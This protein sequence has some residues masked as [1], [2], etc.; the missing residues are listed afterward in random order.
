MSCVMEEDVQHVS[1]GERGWGR[2]APPY[3]HPSA[4]YFKQKIIKLISP[5]FNLLYFLCVPGDVR[6]AMRRWKTS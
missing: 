4:L 2:L 1:P 6:M 3:Y 5:S